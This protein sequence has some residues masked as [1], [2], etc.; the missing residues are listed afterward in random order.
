MT[1]EMWLELSPSHTR[2]AQLAAV[3][4]IPQGDARCCL[5]SA[6]LARSTLQI[7]CR[8]PSC[9]LVPR[10]GGLGRQNLLQVFVS[11]RLH[12]SQMRSRLPDGGR[13]SS[14]SVVYSRWV[15]AL[16]RH[17]LNSFAEG[18]A[19]RCWVR[20]WVPVSTMPFVAL[21][22]RSNDPPAVA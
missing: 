21:G 16:C 18:P 15:Q 5:A 7:R 4:Q 3:R 13:M 20:N 17:S 10:L 8:L 12:C 9:G 22:P 11:G 19:C 14:G 1:P 2:H 6:S